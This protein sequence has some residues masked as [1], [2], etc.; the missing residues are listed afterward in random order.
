MSLQDDIL[1]ML[2]FARQRDAEKGGDGNRTTREIADRTGVPITRVRRAL[3]YMYESDLL[4]CWEDHS[5][6]LPV[7][8]E[9]EKESA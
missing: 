9:C 7:S 4:I 3:N 1:T 2:R 6:S 5:W 8:T